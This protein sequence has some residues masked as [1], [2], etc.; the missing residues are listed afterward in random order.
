MRD[1]WEA[2]DPRPEGVLRLA[3]RFARLGGRGLRRRPR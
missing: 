3:E 1:S 2:L